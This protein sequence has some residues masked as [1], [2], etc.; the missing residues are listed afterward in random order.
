MTASSDILYLVEDGVATLTLNRVH[1]ANALSVE[2]AEQLHHVVDMAASDPQVKVLLLNAN[3]KNFCA[4]AE[5]TPAVLK[6]NIED[7]LNDTC[8]PL[9]LALAEMEKPVIS[10]VNGNAAGIGAAIALAADLCVMADDAQLYFAFSDISLVPDGGCSW[11]LVNQLGS[12]RAFAIIAEAQ[13]L[14]AMTCLNLGLCNKVVPAA[15]L[16]SRAQHWAGKL[17]NRAPLSLRLGKQALRAAQSNSLADSISVEATLQR[18]C[19]LSE[20][21]R[22][23]LTAFGEKRKPVFKGC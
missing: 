8:K 14:D 15:E 6:V 23:A 5:L 1:N 12:K 22:E 7:F 13:R 19:Q 4:G 3:G 10:V 2:F 16:H 18:Q 20:D 21:F 11:Q 17:A 9:L